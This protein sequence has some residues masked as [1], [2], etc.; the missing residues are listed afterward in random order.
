MRLGACVDLNEQIGTAAQ[1]LGHIGD[2]ARQFFAVDCVY[3]VKQLHRGAHLIALQWANQVQIHPLKLGFEIGPFALRFLH[4][5]FTETAMA[6]L[7]HRL[8]PCVWLDFR[9][10][11]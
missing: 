8:N 1:F 6:R 10:S 5:V 4:A 11:D 3:R 2:A 9:D 7:Q